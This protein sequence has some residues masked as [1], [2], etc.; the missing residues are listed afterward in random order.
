MRVV[1]TAALVLSLAAIAAA[2]TP[3]PA[4]VSVQAYYEFML[5]RH[6]ESD[7]NAAGA[8]E[9]LKRAQA[10]DPKS[11]EILA[12]I[13]GHYARQNKGNEAIDAAERALALSATNVE[14]HR[15]LGLVYAAWSDGGVPPPAGKTVAQLR[16]MAI[17][18]L[19]KILE[20]PLA[21][22]DLNLQLT[23]G[24][25]QLRSGHPDRAVPILENI[26]A[27]A[28][29]TTEP[30]TMLAEARLALGRVDAAIEAIEMAAEINP[31][32][33]ATLGDL[34]ERQQKY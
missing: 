28:P 2:Q 7:G 30:Y 13:A 24:R 23:L 14:A 5:A 19:S 15:I 31:R 3:D 1:L 22:T 29:Y 20:S 25:L 32:H 21:A 4:P 6:L 16:E 12:E 9:A 33:Y 8:L 27:Q 34:L 26:V 17:D 11:A 18:H 10:L